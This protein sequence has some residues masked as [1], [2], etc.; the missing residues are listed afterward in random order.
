MRTSV[1]GTWWRLIAL[2]LACTVAGCKGVDQDGGPDGGEYVAPR[3]NGLTATIS[4]CNHNC[5][6]DVFTDPVCVNDAWVCPADY[7]SSAYC[8]THRFCQGPLPGVPL[9]AG[10]GNPC[11][12]AP[13]F[14]CCVAACANH[15][16]TS[17]FCDGSGWHCPAGSVS[18]ADCSG[19]PF[20]LGQ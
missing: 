8:P 4:C 14:F 13:G 2:A 7:V 17:P 12:N 6:N 19:Q 20:C 18:P 3:C 10:T 9:D 15:V 5:D 1:P 11:D 16:T